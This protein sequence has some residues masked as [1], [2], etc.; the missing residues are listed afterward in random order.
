MQVTETLSDG[1]KR[2]FKV[3][4]PLQELDERLSERLSSLKDEV[5]IKGFRPGKVPV[6]HLRRLYGRS[7]MAEIV[8]NTLRDVAKQTLDERGERAA[9]PPDY[10]LPEDQGEA[11]KILT[12]QADLAYTMSYEVLP[13]VVLGDFKKISVER[14]VVEVSEEEVDRQLNQLAESGRSYEPKAGKVENGDRVTLSYVGKIDGEPFEGGKDENATLRI[15]SGQ[16]IPGFEEQVIGLSAS[17]EKTISVTFPENYGA[18]QLA[19]KAATFDVTIK[20]IA[21]PGELVIDDTLATRLGLE[22]LDKLRDAIRDQL[23][24][25][26][27]EAA[28]MKVKRQMLDRLDETHS[29]ELPPKMVE[30]EFQ[31][32]WRQIESDMA[33]NSRTFDQ[34]GTTEEAAKADY[35][36]IAERRVRLGLVLSE[37]G[38]KNQIEVREDELQRALAA[39][40]RNFPGNEK[41]VL[42][43]YRRDPDAINA[44]RAPIFEEK[45]V[46]YL[47]ELVNVTDKPVTREELLKD[48][49]ETAAA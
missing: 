4:V 34:E 38:E 19:G 39:Q 1:L 2:E 18:A 44:L 49:E 45:V 5:R 13:R 9:T 22:S 28:R 15:G 3:V 46:D 25:Q 8:Q 30:A 6:S 42:E 41:Q 17:E 12:G 29:F 43:Y 20:E 16:F 7:A 33:R 40:L 26:Y 31:N 47:L 37:I 11:D 36:K 27:R 48:D 32:I 24:G 10:Q 23:R 14:P 35:R 21:A